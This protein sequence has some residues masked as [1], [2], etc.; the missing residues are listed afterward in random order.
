MDVDLTEKRRGDSCLKYAAGV[1][2]DSP[3]HSI[4]RQIKQLLAVTTPNAVV[5]PVFTQPWPV[6]VPFTRK[7]YA[8]VPQIPRWEAIEEE[9]IER[10][11]HC[12]VLLAAPVTKAVARA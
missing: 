9:G 3:R 11:E 5:P 8:A 12:S 10:T 2:I 6:F 4:R 1:D 7:S